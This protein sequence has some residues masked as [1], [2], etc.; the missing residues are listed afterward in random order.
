MKISA[1]VAMWMCV[2][3]ALVAYGAAYTA[4]SGLQTLTDTAE[5]E[6]ATGYGWFWT[7]LGV[8]ASGFGVLSWLM[9][10]GKLGPAE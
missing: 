6:I 2:A 10:N 1:L 9:K 5:R 7:F 4:F 8:V 3:F